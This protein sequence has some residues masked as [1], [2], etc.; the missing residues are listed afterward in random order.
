[1][2]RAVRV[3]LA[4]YLG[5]INPVSAR[6]HAQ[7]VSPFGSHSGQRVPATIIRNSVR[8]HRLVHWISLGSA[9]YR[10]NGEYG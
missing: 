1:M 6:G 8:H 3:T 10:N 5:Q 4:V 9:T 7:A 2:D